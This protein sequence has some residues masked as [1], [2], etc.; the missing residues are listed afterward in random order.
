M[1][2]KLLLLP[3]LLLITTI[4]HA[5][6]YYWVGGSGNWSDYANHWATSSGG[7]VFHTQ[8]PTTND[9]VFF[10]ANSFNGPDQTVTVDQTIVQCKS[11]WWTGATNTPTL[12]LPGNTTTLRIFGSLTF[13]A[14]M[15]VSLNGV[16]SMEATTPAQ[17]FTS[18]AKH[19][20]AINF[21]GAGGA[22]TLQDDLNVDFLGLIKGSLNTNSKSLGVAN[23]SA[24]A[25]FTAFNFANSTINTL[26]GS[27]WAIES[28]VTIDATNSTI[29]KGGGS[30][31]GGGHTYYNLTA[32][33]ANASLYF[34]D[35]GNTFTG[36]VTLSGDA[37][38]FA[39]NTFNNLQLAPGHVYTFS[40]GT[41][42][43]IGSTITASGNCNAF[44]VLNTGNPV[45]SQAFIKKTSGT[46]NLSYAE[47]KDI[48]V[49]GG[50]VFTASNSIDLGDNTGWTINAPATRNLYW[51]N[52]GGN[53]ND[54]AHW[55]LT[56]GGA[57][58]GCAP[59]PSDN[60]FFDAASFNA[61]DQTVA[62]SIPVANCKNMSW[63]GATNTPTLDLPGNTL[64]IFG[65]LTFIAGMNVSLNGVVS[66]EATTPAQTFTSAAKHFLAINFN[67][68][69][70]AWTLQDD[71]NVDFLGLI[72][73]SLNTNSKS[74]GVAN[75]SA[76]AGFTA[77]NFANSTINTLSGST[78][79]I[80]SSVTI[81]ATNSTIN[82]GGGSFYG[83]GHTYY[84]LTANTANASLYFQ[85]GGN[86]FTGNVTLSGDAGF[87]ADNT[88]N[89]LQLAPGHTYAIANNSTQTITATGNL[90]AIGN[91]GFPIRIESAVA[92]SPATISKSGSGICLDYVRISDI[93]ATGGAF[94][95]AGL[96]PDRSLDMGGNTGWAFTGA[97]AVFYKDADGDGYGNPA[98]TVNGCTP[99]AGYVS[100]NGDCN[101]NNANIHPGAIE[102]CDNHI[103]DNCNG[104]IDEGSGAAVSAGDDVH[105]FFGYT[106]TNCIT[107][108]AV[109]TNGVGT[110]TYQWVL[111]RPLS[112]GE[113]VTGANTNEVKLCLQSNA[114][115]CVTVKDATGCSYSDCAT[116]FVQDIRCS[117]G[118]SRNIKVNICHN[119]NTLCVDQNAV[120]AHLGHGDYLGKCNFNNDGV[121]DDNCLVLYPNPSRGTFTAYINLPESDA[122]T[123]KIQLINMNGLVVKQVQVNGQNAVSFS[124]KDDGTYMLRLTTSKKVITSKVIVTH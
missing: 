58:A 7:A 69:G 64:R 123:A 12:D 33:T 8:V 68:A 112:N 17:T 72:K 6:N 113:S 2:S 13:I 27:T 44:I 84:N 43:T 75:L 96:S 59:N 1:K 115:V 5:T 28:S 63:T 73:G 111:N 11:M 93:T 35:G 92:G 25:G 14:G 105:A 50:A 3:L 90:N 15:N 65:S 37:G 46:V 79:A 40:P 100:D 122:L 77:F 24:F 56:S 45:G 36:N 76:F 89:N 55:S 70:G 74:L 66:M 97:N 23:L 21:N 19:F 10:D 34:Q 32:N 20:L 124:P 80:E 86:T 87:F 16:V 109:V 29:N 91:G 52:N 22:W 38:F 81:D 31:Y 118:N 94:F 49:T 98:L 9:N 47:L 119:G 30:F 101:D 60:V 85:D 104:I 116:I 67:G 41:T 51:V 103:D 110:L 106:A 71:L 107:K 53:W 117:A 18:A 62:I 88:F 95:N 120:P 61:P 108:T 39:D 102:I 57:P 42:Q 26:S 82:K 83:G 54:G 4:S 48:A 114:T 99:P 78:W 121:D